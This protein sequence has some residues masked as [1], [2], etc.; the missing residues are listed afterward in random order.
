MDLFEK[1]IFLCLRNSWKVGLCIWEKKF[2]KEIK[3]YT[4][5]SKWYS[6]VSIKIKAGTVYNG[7]ILRE[8]LRWFLRYGYQMSLSVA[9]LTEDKVFSDAVTCR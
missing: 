5:G 4:D 6:A 3:Y 8:D 1:F 9:K 2:C 7:Y